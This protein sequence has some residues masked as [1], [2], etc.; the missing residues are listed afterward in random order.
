MTAISQH[1]SVSKTAL[2]PVHHQDTWFGDFGK[3]LTNEASE[4][5]CR[6]CLEMLRDRKHSACHHQLTQDTE[7]EQGEPCDN[8]ALPGSEYCE[9]HA[10][11]HGDT[12]PLAQ[13]E[14]AV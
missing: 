10:A 4:V 9:H 11:A 7:W 6:A 5:T 12:E 2:A 8:L 13:W 1:S 3:P 14:A